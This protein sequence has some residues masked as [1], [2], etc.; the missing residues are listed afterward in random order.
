MLLKWIDRFPALIYLGA[1]VLAWTAA[2]MMLDEPLLVVYLHGHPIIRAAVYLT[3]VPGVLLAG[4]LTAR[5]RA[6]FR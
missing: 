2:K 4:S 5:R 6:A 1:G 3:V